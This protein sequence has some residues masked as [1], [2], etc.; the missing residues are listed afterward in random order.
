MNLKHTFVFF[1]SIFFYCIA[2]K[3]QI[4]TISKVIDKTKSISSSQ[5]NNQ[6]RDTIKRK[7]EKKEHVFALN[8]GLDLYK[9]LIL[10]ELVAQNKEY[11][12]YEGYEWAA[13]FSFYRNLSIAIEMGHENKMQKSESLY[14]STIGDYTK[15]GIDINTYDNWLGMRNTIYIGLRYG[16][17][18]HSQELTR[19]AIF[20]R[21]RF[22]NFNEITDGQAIGKR[23]NLNAEWGE[24]IF[25]I[26]TELLFN[27]YL[28]I[29]LQLKYLLNQTYPEN[30]DNLYIPGFHKSLDGTNIG[31]GIN[32]T[33]SYSIPFFKTKL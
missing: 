14:F 21:D 27:I 25:G 4:T 33:L 23:E 13:D 32:Y 3:A 17:S 11:E 24:F 29:G 15:I 8:I 26:K 9:Y 12:Y 19:Y 10:S 22:W 1:I 16:Y 31:I 20:V 6:K 30:F 7:R 5:Q 2:T 28:G 18:K